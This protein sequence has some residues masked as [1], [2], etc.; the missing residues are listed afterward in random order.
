MSEGSAIL[1]S[2]VTKRYRD[3]VA[4]DD[5]SLD[6]KRG[7]IFGLI[8]PDGAGKTTLMR[9]LASLI[10][11]DEGVVMIE[12]M[13][14]VKDFKKVRKIIGYMPGRFSL[15]H[16]LSV[17]ENLKFFAAVFNSR[18]ED[19]YDLIES[20]YS[21][22]ETFKR[23]K[24]GD[25]SGGMKQK[26]ALSCAL[27]HRPR[28]LILDE[29]NTG[30]DAVSRMELWEILHE[31]QGQG[32]TIFISTPYMDEAEA[33]DRVALIQKGRIMSVNT[34]EG[35]IEE[36]NRPIY[37]IRSD[38]IYRLSEDLK[39]HERTDSVY[40]FGQSVHFIPKKEEKIEEVLF[41]HLASKG[42]KRIEIHRIK[43]NIEDCFISLMRQKS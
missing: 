1:F 9:I 10:L 17:E 30:I 22:I 42:H 20:I 12:G 43:P 2:N 7:E 8:G 40:L 29:P 28:V 15:Y 24:A 33:C 25:L 34:P 13:N 39:K 6:V 18:I 32:I 27:I 38:R 19:N 26:L 4:V 23:R 37:S 35:I 21:H 16:D 31:L 36:F 41:K 14:V 3:V 5:V 11:P